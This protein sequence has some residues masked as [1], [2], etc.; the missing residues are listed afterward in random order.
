MVILQLKK[1]MVNS[2]ASS[3]LNNSVSSPLH[4]VSATNHHTTTTSFESSSNH[5]KSS[6]PFLDSFSS[7]SMISSNELFKDRL[8]L[9][10]KKQLSL[11]NYQTSSPTL[12]VQLTP[13][14]PTTPHS[15]SHL[16][17]SPR[18]GK[19]PRSRMQ[20]TGIHLKEKVIEEIPSVFDVCFATDLKK[21]SS[22]QS[23]TILESDE[24]KQLQDTLLAEYCKLRPV[25]VQVD[26]EQRAD[27]TA[28]CSMKPLISITLQLPHLSRKKRN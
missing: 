9:K 7:A 2:S 28:V 17:H 14:T 16:A 26:R 22:H 4:A 20:T 6:T 10:K 18:N 13:S 1:I 25:T 11:N 8:D 21:E 24:L 12:N 3:T 15:P 19:Q 5:C 27:K 23:G